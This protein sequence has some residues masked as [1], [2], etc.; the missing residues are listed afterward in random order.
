MRLVEEQQIRRFDFNRD[1]YPFLIDE[2]GDFLQG[3]STHSRM[4]PC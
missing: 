1:G 2:E 3:L 4:S